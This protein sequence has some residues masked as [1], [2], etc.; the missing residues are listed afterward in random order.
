MEINLLGQNAVDIFGNT[1]EE[2]H[3]N[4]TNFL[5]VVGVERWKHTSGPEFMGD[6]R[7]RVTLYLKN[8]E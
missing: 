7:Y 6:D 4:A 3:E 2:A 5:Y 1:S 8:G